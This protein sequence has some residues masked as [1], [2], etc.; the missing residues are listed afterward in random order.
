MT[1]NRVK[2]QHFTFSFLRKKTATKVFCAA[3]Y[4]SILFKINTVGWLARAAT[5]SMDMTMDSSETSLL[6]VSWMDG[7]VRTGGSRSSVLGT[8]EWS[9]G[10]YADG[11]L[12]QVDYV[13]P[14]GGAR[15]GE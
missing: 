8:G 9:Q 12:R 7:R 1:Y 10:S 5:V 14:E 3:F 4:Y 6:K 15:G 2:L 13:V 11:L